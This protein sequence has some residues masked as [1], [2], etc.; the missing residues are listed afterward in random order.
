M[1]GYVRPVEGELLVKD[2][3]LYRAAYCGMCRYGG[4]HTSFLTRFLLNYDF[5]LLA[6]LRIS[7]TDEKTELRKAFCPYAP[8]KKNMLYAEEAFKHTLK[9]FSVLAYYNNEDDI[10]DSSGIK[11]L[12]HLLKK[13]IFKSMLKNANGFDGFI[14]ITTEN[15]DRL[16]AVEKDRCGDIDIAADPF[17]RIIASAASYGLK[18]EA[19]QIADRCGYHLGRF[20]YIADAIDDLS[21]DIKNKSYNPLVCCGTDIEEAKKNAARTAYDSMMAFS[22]SYGLWHRTDYDRIIYN[23]C[24]L[25]GRAALERILSPKEKA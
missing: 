17:A 8:K 9:C 2:L 13:P 7:L 6:L 4:K 15:L 10:S 21:D 19:W 5:V 22:A 1:F 3:M 14:K 16:A 23:I 12:P 25:G 24:E 11:R 20:I 18:G